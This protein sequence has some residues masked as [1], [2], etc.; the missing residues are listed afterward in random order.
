MVWLAQHN[1]AQA[2]GAR[3]LLL[4]EPRLISGH[5]RDNRQLL[6]VLPPWTGSHGLQ[7][8]VPQPEGLAVGPDGTIYLVSEPN[9]FYRFERHSGN[10]G[11]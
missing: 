10:A 1:L 6:G 2:A 7:R 3:F 9:L 8:T 4:S 11:L 5:G